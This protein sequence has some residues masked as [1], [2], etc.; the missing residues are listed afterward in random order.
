[1]AGSRHALVARL[2]A[3]LVAAETDG[4]ARVHVLVGPPGVGKSWVTHRLYERLSATRD[5]GAYWPPSLASDPDPI[6]SRHMLNP[7]RGP[8]GSRPSW[9]W[10]GIPCTELAGG[11]RAPAVFASWTTLRPHLRRLRAVRVRTIVAESVEVADALLFLLALIGTT[12]P[13]LGFVVSGASALTLLLRLRSLPRRLRRAWAARRGG[14][15]DGADPVHRDQVDDIVG[16]VVR[17]SRSAPAVLVVDDAHWSD[18]TVAGLVD[19]LV[20]RRGAHVLVVLCTWPR[21]DDPGG[22][23]LPT[24][25]EELRLRGGVDEVHDLLVDTPLRPDELASILA[26]A[27]ARAA[28]DVPLPDEAVTAELCRRSGGNPLAALMLG[29]SAR[30]HDLLRAGRLDVT[31]AAT[32]RGDLA[33]S[34]DEYW[35]SLPDRLRRALALA[36]AVGE[37][38]PLHPVVATLDRNGLGPALPDLDLA[39]S[40]LYVLDRP[41][42]LLRRF[43]ERLFLEAARRLADESIP[44]RLVSEVAAGIA[45]IAADDGLDAT[46]PEVRTAALA[47]HVQFALEGHVDRAAALRSCVLLGERAARRHAYRSALEATARGDDL[48]DGNDPALTLR[49]RRGRAEWLEETGQGRAAVDAARGV[50]AWADAEPGLDPEGRASARIRLGRALI[51]VAAFP[52]ARAILAAVADDGTIAEP[53][54]IVAGER[55]AEAEARAG[56]AREAHARLT[57]LADRV[58]TVTPDAALQNRALRLS[59]AK[60]LMRSGRAADVIDEL[61]SSRTDAIE[62]SGRSSPEA[63]RAGLLVVE[64]LEALRVTEAER[65]ADELLDVVRED[66][67][68]D[69]PRRLRVE[70]RFLEVQRSLGRHERV[71]RDARELAVRSER[72]VG[73]TNA[74][75]LRIRGL[76]VD[77]LMGL[78]DPQEAERECDELLVAL[79]GSLGRRDPDALLTRR[80]R[81][82]ILLDTGRCA[83]ALEELRQLLPLTREVRGETHRSTRETEALLAE[84]EDCVASA[85][86]DDG[87]HTHGLA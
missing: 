32:L 2:E 4:R 44:S 24:W 61:R 41:T 49:L 67:D 55:A 42:P 63:I 6:R 11:L 15:K 40:R 50:V 20:D 65:C 28:P 37:S 1:M 38:F 52:E 9:L 13:P 19:G 31:T 57:A 81:A 43:T 87:G 34:L 86:M 82:R 72:A 30:T 58:G 46:D 16:E 45:E 51:R 26:G 73:R 83:A 35:R 29:Y 62:A 54:R 59:A 68:D 80:R 75:T 70:T 8:V 69:D 56:M 60:V 14:G 23:A 53:T 78:A 10:W 36:S 17:A 7:D 71:V 47:A 12:L 85:V 84:A 77:G 64:A 27:L 66:L 39:A 74:N 76:I 3:A 18:E 79:H 25:L 21:S 22:S 48:D 33:T 5:A